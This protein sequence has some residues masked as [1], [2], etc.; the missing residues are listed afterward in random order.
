MKS[1]LRFFGG[2]SYLAGWLAGQLPK[3]SKTY[4]EVFAGGLSLLF[5]RNPIGSIEVAN[6]IWGEL[7]NFYRVLQNE[8][9]FSTFSRLC[10]LTPRSEPEF[11]SA[12]N[13]ILLNM[14]QFGDNVLKA[15]HFFIRNRMSFSG[16]GTTYAPTTSRTRRGI[17]ENV[18]SWLSIVDMLPEFHQ[19]LRLVEIRQMDFRLF[20]P[21]YDSPDAVFYLDP[22]YLSETRSGGGYE[23]EMSEKDHLDLLEM[24]SSIKG[25]FLLSGYPSKMYSE[26]AE[27]GGFRV[28]Q[29]EVTKASSTKK[30]SKP[31]G[32][33]TTWRNYD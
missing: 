9:T 12:S 19:R 8:N 7:T 4:F 10:E 24:L 3:D 30:Q 29:I 25:R 13:H 18:S 27:R 20:I 21:Q 23:H 22:T 26:W 14:Q 16:T 11:K 33:E 5:H 1:P 17:N 6:D 2:K 28:N 32:V 15:W 31:K